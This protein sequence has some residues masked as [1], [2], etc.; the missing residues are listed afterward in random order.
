MDTIPVHSVMTVLD[1]MAL[2]YAKNV[3]THVCN[4]YCI[5]KVVNVL[6]ATN[7]VIL[8]LEKFSFGGKLKIQPTTSACCY[9]L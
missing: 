1:S 6:E 9:F 4:Y 7:N 5:N 2:L 3:V 8:N